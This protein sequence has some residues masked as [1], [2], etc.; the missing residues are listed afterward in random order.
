MSWVSVDGGAG[1]DTLTGSASADSLDGGDDTDKVVQTSDEAAQ[2]LS[3]SALVAGAVSDTIA[4]IESAE[5]TGG[6]AANTIDAGAFTGTVTISGGG[7]ADVLTGGTGNDSLSGGLGN[8]TLT[9]GLGDDS[10]DG[11]GDDLGTDSVVGGEGDA[12]DTAHTDRVVQSVDANQVLTDVQ[13]TGSGID[14]ISDIE[15]ASLTGGAS[16]NTIDASAFTLGAVTIDGGAG[17]DTLT[18]SAAA[19]DISG[20]DGADTIVCLLYTS[21]S[22]RD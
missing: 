5:L 13:L 18:G 4:N 3:D 11:G 19:D 16:A 14:V 21:P 15:E 7:G 6:D 1:A 20:G 12:A 2:S 10:I 9:G 22:P 8:D 17:D